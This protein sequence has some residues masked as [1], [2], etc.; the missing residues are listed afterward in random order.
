[1]TMVE[2]FSEAKQNRVF[3]DVVGRIE[4]AIISGRL[5]PGDKLPAERELKEILKTSRSSLREALRVLEQKG[6]IEIKL[7]MG[8][9]AVVKRVSSDSVTQSLD[10]LIRSQKVSLDHLAEFRERVEGDVVALVAERARQEDINALRALL[11]KAENCVR[12]GVS[13][14]DQFL[15]ADR[16]LHLEFA[17]ITGNPVYVT[18]LKIVQNNM[19]TYS[20]KY[21]A[22]GKQELDDNLQDL[23]TIVE[24]VEKG[25]AEAARTLA[26]EHV[27]RFKVYLQQH[28]RGQRPGAGTPSEWQI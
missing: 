15:D 4:E 11:R 18:V 12:C 13:H 24:A 2:L 9:G 10:L 16:Q 17:Q 20:K 22:M 28:T 14:V 7:G 6:L 1:M 5:H 23:R 21:L 3:Q 8:G 26:R 25:Q 19:T 27:R